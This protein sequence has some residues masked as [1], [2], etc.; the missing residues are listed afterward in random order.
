MRGATAN[1]KGDN[2][3]PSWLPWEVRSL[4]FDRAFGV[5]TQKEYDAQIDAAWVKAR[6]RGWR[7]SR[8]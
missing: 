7:G 3:R 1:G 5:I 2:T 8:R 6:K 4:N